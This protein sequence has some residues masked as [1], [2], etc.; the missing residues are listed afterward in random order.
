MSS[1][2]ASI[3][4]STSPLIASSRASTSSST[5]NY[6][7]AAFATLQSACNLGEQAPSSNSSHFSALSPQFGF[8]GITPR[9]RVSGLKSQADNNA[10]VLESQGTNEIFSLARG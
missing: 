7:A 2:S 5:E 6:A 10:R 9:P 1:A 3:S 4:S 8:G